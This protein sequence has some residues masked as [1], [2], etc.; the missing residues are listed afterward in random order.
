[1]QHMSSQE[2]GR[3]ISPVLG[4]Q[5]KWRTVKVD[6]NPSDCD[7]SQVKESDRERFSRRIAWS[8][9]AGRCAW[10]VIA[11]TLRSCES[12][13]HMVGV[14]SI[15]TAGLRAGTLADMDNCKRTA[16]LV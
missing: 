8:C 16:W 4:V 13:L 7:T 3:A 6:S 1:M 10:A 15:R 11:N 5:N 14:L 12:R 9:H 2:S